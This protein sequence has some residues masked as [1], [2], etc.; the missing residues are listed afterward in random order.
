METAPGDEA[1][2][3]DALV[4]RESDR[5][6]RFLCW[7]LGD[8]ED[9]LDALQETLIRAHRGFSSLRDKTVATQWLYVIAH[10]VSYRMHSR[11]KGRHGT[12]GLEAPEGATP[13]SSSASAPTP[14]AEV[15]ARET[16]R[17]L[18]DALAELKPE[19]RTALLLFT[20]GGLKYR[21]IAEATGCPIA[22]VATRIRLAR[23]QVAQRL[24]ES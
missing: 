8:R 17:R 20:L 22:T 2:T 14:L 6:F 21:E 9:A 5:V 12:F 1:A 19:L 4:A 11:R 18:A 24:G 23:E 10:N 3:F 7:N 13:V 16:D 15:E